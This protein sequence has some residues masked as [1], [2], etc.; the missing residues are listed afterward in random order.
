VRD[1]ERC[2]EEADDRERHAVVLGE[3]VGDRADVG[4]VPREQPADGEARDDAP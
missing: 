4:D 3:G 1:E 2:R